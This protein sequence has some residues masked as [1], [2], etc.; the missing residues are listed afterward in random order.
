MITTQKAMNR[1][2]IFF[3]F[4]LLYLYSPKI[5]LTQESSD[6]LELWYIYAKDGNRYFGEILEKTKRSIVFNT[7][8]VGEITLR[9]KRIKYMERFDKASLIGDKYWPKYR[10]P[11]HNIIT[12]SG[13]ASEAYYKNTFVY[14]NHLNV[15]LEDFLSIS[16]GL[17]PL[18]AS[19]FE[20]GYLWISPKVS[21][22]T[23]MKN[24]DFSVG[25][26][27]ATS[28][29]VGFSELPRTR[30]GVLYGV[31]TFG[32]E[33]Y[34][35]SFGLGYGMGGGKL[36]KQ[37]FY[38]MNAMYRVGECSFLHAEI[39]GGGQFGI[40][41]IWSIRRQYTRGVVDLGWVFRSNAALDFSIPYTG[42]IVSIMRPL[43]RK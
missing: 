32:N 10:F 41:S 23:K 25:Y 43:H 1:T 29:R 28:M 6:S 8:S 5:G 20:G 21:V 35:A 42:P 31:G 11:Y 30:I 16:V 7:Q 14:F 27:G 36:F 24:I 34:S 15:K 26:F 17:T 12:P 38:S 19:E 22:P 40:Y 13:K 18:I 37:P 33:F 39:I 4:I 2:R 3:F 9:K